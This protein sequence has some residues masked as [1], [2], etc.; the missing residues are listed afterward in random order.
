M[1]QQQQQ[2]QQQQGL[3]AQISLDLYDLL[4]LDCKYEAEN[5]A[6][7]AGRVH[8]GRIEVFSA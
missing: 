8:I 1:Q 2:Q 7:S 4:M 6:G 5:W 3:L